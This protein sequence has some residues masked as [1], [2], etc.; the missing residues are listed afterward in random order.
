MDRQ[1]TKDT[2]TVFYFQNVNPEVLQLPLYFRFFTMQDQL[3]SENEFAV[4]MLKL[5]IH[6]A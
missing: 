5:H 4:K 3:P 1:L 2:D 6:Q